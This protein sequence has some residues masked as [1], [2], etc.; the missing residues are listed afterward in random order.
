[1]IWRIRIVCLGVCVTLCGMLTVGIRP[2]PVTAA[3]LTATDDAGPPAGGHGVALQGSVTRIEF[4][5]NPPSSVFRSITVP[6]EGADVAIFARDCCIRDDVVLVFVDGCRVGTVDSRGGPTG[7]HAGGT[8]TVSLP[9]GTHEVEYRNVTT[10]VGPS[11]WDVSESLHPHTGQFPCE[12]DLVPRSLGYVVLGDSTEQPNGPLPV[13]REFVA[14]V[15]VANGGSSDAGAFD[16]ALYLSTDASVDPTVDAL[17]GRLTVDALTSQV[18]P[19][20]SR[21]VSETFLLPDPLPTEYAGEVFLGVVVD[22]SNRVRETDESNNRDEGNEVGVIRVRLY[23][24]IAPRGSV[25]FGSQAEAVE[26]LRGNGFAEPVLLFD[27]GW[28]RPASS[29]TRSRYNGQDMAAHAFRIQASEPAERNGRWVVSIQGSEEGFNPAGL[30]PHVTE[31]SPR[32]V[33]DFFFQ[34]LGWPFYVRDYHDRF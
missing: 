1:M 20:G 33:L 24:P 13:N 10:R 14:T 7:S 27:I 9:G 34:D 3:E 12:V 2:F 4:A 28:S 32:S 21:A 6:P 23:D 8:V 22:P 31:P 29:P 11:G 5:Q 30:F 26:F 16:I 17:V 25:A 15:G 19:G 18:F